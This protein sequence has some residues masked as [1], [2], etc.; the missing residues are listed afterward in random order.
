MKHHLRKENNCLNCGATVT[1]RFCSHC[2]QENIET[3]ETTGYLLRHFFEDI[4]HY[5]SKFLTTLK[6]LLFKPGYLTKEYFAGRRAA[7]LNPI[8]MYIFISA[9]FFLVLFIRNKN[10]EVA[11]NEVYHTYST[12]SVRQLMAD[13]LRKN[14][15][16]LSSKQPYDSIKI[17]ALN[18]IASSFDTVKA[19]ESNNEA[20]GFGIGGTG[21]KF[22]MIED[23]YNSVH[24]YDSVQQ[25]LPDSLRDH[26]IMRWMLRTNISLKER[27]GSRSHV[28]VEENFQHSIP[29]L[30]FILLPVFALFIWWFHSRKKYYYAQNVIFSIHFH[31]FIFFLFLIATLLG[32]FIPI[33]GF[34]DIVAAIAVIYAFIY[35]VKALKNVY[36]QS[37]VRAFFKALAVSIIYLLTLIIGLVLLA[38]FSFFTA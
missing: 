7:Y 9:V 12:N 27:Y 3:K 20:I 6:D 21:A 10:E 24:E 4:T 11:K 2:G 22:T 34:S 33:N 1:D 28:V 36:E 38:A 5:D 26:G 14:I 35:L 15:Q 8:R 19:S 31:S 29:R 16:A 13:S 30:M 37:A 17:R 25:A 23:R 18:D 32:W